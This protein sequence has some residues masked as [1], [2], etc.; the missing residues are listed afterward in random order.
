MSCPLFCMR[1][2][3]GSDRLF[4]AVSCIPALCSFPILIRLHSPSVLKNS[5]GIPS[6]SRLICI[7]YCFASPLCSHTAGSSILSL[8]SLK[9]RSFVLDVPLLSHGFRLLSLSLRFTVVFSISRHVS[10]LAITTMLFASLVIKNVR[11]T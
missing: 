10:V 3:C 7:Q 9:R 4:C 8:S 6:F 1:A 11:Q 2:S 5:V